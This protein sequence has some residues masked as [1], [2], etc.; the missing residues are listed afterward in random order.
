M[1]TSIGIFLLCPP[2]RGHCSCF[3]V[4]N[5]HR[6]GIPGPLRGDRRGRQP[7]F[8]PEASLATPAERSAYG[9]WQCVY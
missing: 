5:R 3:T 2:R 1:E 9:T 7:G 6:A 4:R 8:R